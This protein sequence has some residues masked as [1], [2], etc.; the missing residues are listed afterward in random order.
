MLILHLSWEYPPLVYGGLGRH[1]H[2][3]AEEQARQGHEVTVVTQTEG[4]AETVDVNGVRVI[5]V[6]R[7][8]PILPFDG[9]HL[10][11]WV[12][13]LEHA[14]TRALVSLAADYNPDVVH[15]HD[16]L[17]AHT[18]I[19]SQSVFRAPVVTTLHATEAGRQLGWL[20]N[21]LS[22]AIHSVEWWLSH[23]ST[24]V[25]AC[26]AHMQWEISRLF[27][28]P[29]SHIDVIPN[30]IDL[31]FWRADP[32]A[33]AE[34]RR[35]YAR[36]G[37]LLVYVGRLEWEK[38]VHTLLE[39]LPEVLAEHPE[40]R[41]VVA[42]RGGQGEELKRLAEHLDLGSRALFPG[43]LPEEQMHGL[44]AAADVTVVPSLYEPFGLVALEAAALRS[45][46]V[47]AE[48]GGLAEFA[49]GD[50][51]ALTFGRGD[52]ADL[53][54]TILEVL[55]DQPATQQRRAVAYEA[56][57]TRY[58][59]PTITKQTVATYQHA[60]AEWRTAG[61]RRPTAPQAQPGAANLLYGE[62][63]LRPPPVTQ[64]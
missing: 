34:A 40:A 6:P 36:G 9:V 28:Y 48:T 46:V 43:Y 41:L 39:A 47:V 56:L 5:R 44:M 20:T 42:G 45:P 35:D 32:E 11:G 58:S 62:A 17:V 24:R 37:P 19:T 60:V 53:A 4:P 22:I 15:A 8:P 55:A 7:D 50:H 12:A 14:F 49:D 1:V 51:N 18:A 25:I 61:H 16:W 21:E 26:S 52:P 63:D 23:H 3:L 38:G 10:L 59:W 57:A 2:A 33:V 13:G 27:D 30:G 64:D 31:V 29:R 54:R